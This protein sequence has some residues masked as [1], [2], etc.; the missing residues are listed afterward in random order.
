MHLLRELLSKESIDFLAIQ[1]SIIAGDTSNIINMVWKH[2]EFGYCKSAANVA[3][4][5]NFMFGR[6]I[7]SLPDFFL[8]EQ[9]I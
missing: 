3:L 6:M 2:S 5:A 8:Q 9:G 4:E 1:E 7:V